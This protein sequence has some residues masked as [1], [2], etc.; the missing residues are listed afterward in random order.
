MTNSNRIKKRALVT[1]ATGF[2]G[3]H[4]TKR[5]VSDGWEVH[6][7]IRPESELRQ[8]EYL[9]DRVT[10][11]RHDGSTEGIFR[12]IEDSKPDIVLHLAS[13]FLA[14]HSPGDIESMIRSNVTFGT[15]LVE[16]MTANGVN[17]LIN[18]GTS[19]Q[20]FENEDYNPACLYA[21]TKQ[22]FEDILKYYTEASQLKVITLKLFDTYGPDDPRDK[23][24]SLLRKNKGNREPL[25]MSP[26]EQLVDLAY[27]DDVA[28]VFIL[29][30][31]RLQKGIVVDYEEYAVSSGCPIKLKDIVAAYS[32]V[33][34]KD[35]QIEWGGRPY[36]DREVMVP[37]SSGRP[38]PGWKTKVSLEDGIRRME[39]LSA[40]AEMI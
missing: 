40:Y 24:F 11:H 39:G 33:T 30:A 16:V 23:L 12:I 7:I 6:L 22:A 35:L 3:S 5:L 9:L 10:L 21:A 4:L 18:T 25:L 17:R 36:R 2:V 37:W 13:M 31:E 32:K 29:A 19:W 27:I 14:K 1:G 15:Q 20:H 34:G 8:I 28:E 26:G 38:F